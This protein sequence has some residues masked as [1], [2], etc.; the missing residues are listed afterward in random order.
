MPVKALAYFGVFLIPAI[1]VLRVWLVPRGPLEDWLGKPCPE[2]PLSCSIVS[3]FFNSSI[4]S[5]WTLAVVAAVFFLVQGGRIVRRY[6]RRARRSA[7]DLV[8]TSGSLVGDVV[9]RDELCHILME[10]LRDRTMRRP[11]LVIG[12]MGTGKTALFLRLTELLA[13]RNA[14]PV[15][16][17]LRDVTDEDLLDFEQLAR[18]RFLKEIRLSLKSDEEGTKTWR[19]LLREDRIVV[20]ADGAEE[21]LQ[22]SASKNGRD[23]SIRDAITKA[24]KDKLPLIIASRPHAAIKGT[25]ASNIYMEPLS[26]E[27]A[28][29]YLQRVGPTDDARRLDRIVDTADVADAPLYLRITRE[30][31]NEQ[32]LERFE[33]G[34]HAERLETRETDRVDLRGHLMETWLRALVMVHLKRDVPLQL[35]DRAAVVE[36]LSGL[37]CIGLA[38]DTAVVP[39]AVL[40]SA[41]DGTGDRTCDDSICRSVTEAVRARIEKYC[42]KTVQPRLA[43]RYGTQLGLVEAYGDD[44]RFPHTIVQSYLGSRLIKD[45]IEN[46]DYLRQALGPERAGRELLDAL[47]MYARGSAKAPID[48]APSGAAASYKAAQTDLEKIVEGLTERYERT[49]RYEGTEGYERWAMGGQKV[50]WKSRSAWTFSLRHWRSTVWLTP[51]TTRNW[52]PSWNRLG[53]QVSRKRRR[54]GWRG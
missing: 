39:C 48:K 42:W 41:G 3:G 27:A 14:V 50:R 7:K 13:K 35:R 11:Q 24:N 44:V 6:R 16:I 21:A 49:E 36:Q 33:P 9:G 54:I 31:H 34:R 32:L 17:R 18:E 26:R 37:A 52:R 10:H 25:V 23:N 2:N 22:A 38:R 8:P 46:D 1:I 43:V 20:L 40:D 5:L 30:L 29:D 53:A 45:A 47:V 15:S 19:N 28:L 4:I 51:E 12:D